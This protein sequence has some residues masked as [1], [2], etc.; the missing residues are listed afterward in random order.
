MRAVGVSLRR[1]EVRMIDHPEPRISSPDE[2][3]LRILEVGVCGTDREICEFKF[4]EAPGGSEFLVLGHEA[5]AE[6]VEVGSA[7][8]HLTPGTL[9]VPMVRLPCA[10]PGCRACLAQRQDFCETDTFPEH[11]IRRAH[12]FMTERVIGREKFLVPVPPELREVAVLVEPLTILEKALAELPAIQSRMP[13][14]TAPGPGPG[15]RALV[16]G[17]G[18]VGLLGAMTFLLRGCDTTVVARSPASTPNADV[19]TAIGA[20]YVSSRE[21]PLRELAAK[22]GR[23]D[24]IYE[25]A[26]APAAAF[27]SLSALATNGV[28]ILTGVPGREPIEIDGGGV[29]REMV[30]RNQ[31][32]LGT[33]NADRD[34]FKRAIADLR[35]MNERWPREV[36]RLIT[37]RFP[38]ESYAEL[39][40]E[41]PRGIKSILVV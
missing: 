2:V 27:E 33:V 40:L 30:L 37:G 24:V 19:T 41:K 11:G 7:V 10:S 36:R 20:R 8:R 35:L 39:L 6:V 4:G 17:A 21:L 13:W 3:K 38:L 34:S 16:L 25:A 5:V 12:G 29:V 32:L 18:P 22:T 31:I 28:S 1:R 23:Y 15:D 9:V 14:R 26:G